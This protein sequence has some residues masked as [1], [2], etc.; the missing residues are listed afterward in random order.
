MIDL[1]RHDGRVLRIGHRG[2]AALAAENTL[3]ALEE[4]MLHRVDAIEFDV[5]PTAEGALV[6]AHSP[7]LTRGDAVAP[8]DRAL[9]VLADRAPGIGIQIDMKRAG[10]EEGVLDAVRRHGLLDRTFVS[11]YFAESLRRVGELEP[12]LPVSWTYPY[13][14]YGLSRRWPLAPAVW[15]GVVGLRRALPY[16]IERLL[17]RSGAAAATL[18]WAVVS[19]AVV[20][21]CHARGAAVLAWTV[22]HRRLARS[23]VRAG[24]DG[25][26]TNDPRIFDGG[27]TR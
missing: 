12:A 18:H 1:R 22:D 11:S 24:V 25:I 6:L 2:A 4:A 27:P 19:R 17:D 23:L 21:R 16:R 14:R 13:D 10:Y 8:L 20:R 15:S 9:E 3:D 5:L 26:I 7:D